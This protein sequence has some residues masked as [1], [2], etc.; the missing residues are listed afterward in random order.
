M[1][2]RTFTSHTFICSLLDPNV[3][4][5]SSCSPAGSSASCLLACSVIYDFWLPLSREVELQ[6]SY[7]GPRGCVPLC[8]LSN[9]TASPLSEQ[10]VIAVEIGWYEGVAGLSS[11]CDL[12]GLDGAGC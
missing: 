2:L 6:L 3:A 10:R 12:V 9:S 8:K 1:P 4:I 5:E 7:V 11:F